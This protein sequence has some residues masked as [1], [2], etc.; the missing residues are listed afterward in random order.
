MFGLEY[1]RLAWL[2]RS[3]PELFGQLY[4]LPWYRETQEQ[5]SASRLIPGGA[6]L[7][8]GCA[9]GDLALG[10]AQQGMQVWVVDKSAHMLQAARRHASGVRLYQADAAQLPFPDGQFDVALAAS[11][12]NVVDDPRAV[13]TEMQRVV[14]SGGWVSVLLPDLRFGDIEAERFVQETGL[15]D[16]SR[17]AFM[18]WH[19]LARKM[20]AV[21]VRQWFAE[22]GMTHVSSRSWLGG[23]VSSIS[24][25]IP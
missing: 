11:L 4:R 22:A 2:M 9:A 17:A 7:E 12:L 14:R 25:R 3:P 5:W 8:I 1:V 20:D 15:H 10:L 6:L 13:I 18:A 21:V 24:G 16:F 23:M 19:R